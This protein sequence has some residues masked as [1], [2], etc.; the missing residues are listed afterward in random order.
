MSQQMKYSFIA[1]IVISVILLVSFLT[2]RTKRVLEE[3]PILSESGEV[4]EKPS[5]SDLRSELVK[6]KDIDVVIGDNEAPITIFEYASYSC[7]HCANFSARVYP[8]LKEEYIDTGKVRFIL[9]DF[10]LDEPSLRAAQ[11]TR[12]INKDGYEA[13]SKTLF[14]QRQNWAYGKEFP[15]KLEN[16]AKIIGIS[17]DDFHAC[18]GNKV[19]EEKILNYRYEV[20]KAYNLSSTPSLI[21]NGKKYN[22]NNSFAAL[23]EYLNKL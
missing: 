17:G 5:Y 8:K 1:I 21:I 20:S 22:G 7:S 23:S 9:R 11:L 14:E 16:I 19:I 12:C 15:E 6:I 13:L 10:P 18:V 4:I 2:F 3:N